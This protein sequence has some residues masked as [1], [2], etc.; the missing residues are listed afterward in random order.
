MSPDDLD[1]ESDYED[2][3]VKKF[4]DGLSS[5]YDSDE[6][7]SSSATGEE[8]PSKKEGKQI[9]PKM[10]RITK[11]ERAC[12]CAWIVKERKDGKMLNGR[13]IRNGGAKGATMTATSAEVKTSGAYES[14]AL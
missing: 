1:L 10:R 11:E 12:V 5:S 8:V 3:D 13:W 7:C 2:K 4:D 6:S 9:T 14:L